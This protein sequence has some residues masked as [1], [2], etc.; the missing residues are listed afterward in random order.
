MKRNRNA[1]TQQ[2]V[3]IVHGINGVYRFVVAAQRQESARSFCSHPILQRIHLDIVFRRIFPNKIFRGILM[4][5]AVHGN[6]GI[7]ENLEVRT[8]FLITIHCSERGSKVTTG[9]AP[10]YSDLVGIYIPDG[11]TVAYDF[12]SAPRV[13]QRYFLMAI[14]HTVF[15]HTERNALF[16]H[17]FDHFRTLVFHS[18]TIVASARATDYRL[19]VWLCRR[20]D[21]KSW[22]GHIGNSGSATLKFL[23]LL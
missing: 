3:H 13:L 10:H 17:P 6:D 7:K 5:S 14:G 18:Q 21:V 20:I 1:A 16:V 15:E 2:R 9:R 8:K 22:V 23:G 11:S 12:Y 19:P 4:G